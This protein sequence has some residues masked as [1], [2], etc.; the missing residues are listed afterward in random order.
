MARNDWDKRILRAED[1][2]GRGGAAAE[3]VTFYGHVLGLQQELY[4]VLSSSPRPSPVPGQT[5]RS[6]IDVEAACQWLP[7]LLML[8]Q[9]KGPAKLAAEA[10]RLAATDHQHQLRL[11]RDFLESEAPPAADS[12]SFLVR[13]VLQPCAEFL[14]RQ[15]GRPEGFGG[16]TCPICGDK[17]QFAVLRPEGDGAKRFL[18][19]SFCLTEWE[20][21][22][23]LCPACGE[24]NSERLPRYSTDDWPAIRVEA[25]ETCKCYLKSVDLTVDGLAV[26]VVDEAA[27]AA[28]DLWAGERRYQKI[29]P[30][31]MGF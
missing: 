18:A 8:V 21:R 25:C 17:P 14:A 28:L 26:P 20:F 15:V 6:G 4:D 24:Q 2:A 3:V 27:A 29:Q 19:C 12:V 22:R 9:R 30:N 31:L 10:K 7:R 11:L 13:A 16:S 23:M 5:F 1:L